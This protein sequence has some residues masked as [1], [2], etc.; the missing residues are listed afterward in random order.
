MGGAAAGLQFAGGLGLGAGLVSGAE[1]AIG[2]SPTA[3]P[4]AAKAAA[5]GLSIMDRVADVA[6][7][8]GYNNFYEF[9]LEKS[10]PARYAPRMLKVRPWQVS[11]EGL[12][13]RPQVV[14]ID[15]LAKIAPMEE[16]IYRLRCV[17]GWSMVIP[18]IGYS[19][20]QLIS[21]V[22]PLGTAKFVEFVTLADAK[23]MPGLSARVLRWPYHE[24]LRLDEAQH[25]LTLLTF[26]MY[27]HTL[28]EQNGAPIRLVVPWKY[29]FK[30]IK[31][32]VAIRFVAEQPSTSWSQS[33][34][35]EY[36]FYSNVNPD[37]AHPRWSQAS[38]RV[39][40]VGNRLFAPRR[41]TERFNGYESL[42]A[43]L[44]QGLDLKRFY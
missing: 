34:P 7:A 39:L 26:G 4:L 24:G 41:A 15:D 1:A 8:T 2:Q 6:D 32:I 10:D 13:K 9:G 16:R 30:S 5:P 40:G 20:S 23:Q 43:S 17:E 22:E 38:E 3:R 33:A 19:F 29:G 27:G 42:V 31:S 14:G 37:V 18:W 36:G 25:P 44:Y 11:I 12:V 21:R 28:P 35:Q